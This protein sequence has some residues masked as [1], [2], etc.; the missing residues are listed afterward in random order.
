MPPA[1]EGCAFC[2]EA[3]G[4]RFCELAG[5]ALTAP[6]E[7]IERRRCLPRELIFREG[8][9]AEAAHCIRSG[10]VKLYKR[11][12]KGEPL[13]I[14]L[15]GGGRLIG[16]RAVLAGEFYAA[17][18]EAVD[19]VELCTIPGPTFMG[20]LAES[21]VLGQ[22]LLAMMARELRVSEEQTLALA[23]D[24]VR[25]RTVRLLIDFLADTGT[26][27]G[28]GNPVLVP[29][30]RWELAQ[31]VSTSPETLSRTLHRLAKEGVL[32]LTRTEIYVQDPR[33]LHAIAGR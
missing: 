22:R 17:T 30:Q 20:I 9:P 25:A 7:G 5:I 6:W 31:M 12:A 18:A 8:S 19:A 13:I 1:E 27:L 26:G 23:H 14:R 3:T 28:P 33:R 10:I 11:G 32:H 21:T 24:T 2:Q 15:L 16:Y 29:L 4:K